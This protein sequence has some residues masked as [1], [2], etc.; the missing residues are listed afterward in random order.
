M[1]RSQ[2]SRGQ[3]AGRGLARGQ[4]LCS[5]GAQLSTNPFQNVMAR[6]DLCSQGGASHAMVGVHAVKDGPTA[7]LH[8]HVGGFEGPEWPQPLQC[9]QWQQ[10][11]QPQQTQLQLHTEPQMWKRSRNL[12]GRGCSMEPL[13]PMKHP[14]SVPVSP[15]P[16]HLL[17]TPLP[18]PLPLPSAEQ[19]PQ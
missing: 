19:Q 8:N 2:A 3:G 6:H 7:T 9:Q 14:S 17:S 16:P 18:S 12:P 11:Q 4:R 10:H 15:S 13:R 1:G 5:P